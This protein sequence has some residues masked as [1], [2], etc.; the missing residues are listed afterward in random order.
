MNAENTR[1]E[2]L[3]T[4]SDGEYIAC[5]CD[6]A[7]PGARGEQD[8][9]GGQWAEFLWCG[10]FSSDMTGAKALAVAQWGRENQRRV[11]RF[12]Y[13]GHGQSSG[14]F[15]DGTIGRWKDDAAF[16]RERLS[17]GRQILIGSSMGGWIS[18]LLALEKPQNLAGLLL[19]AP[20]PD[21][22]ERLLWANFSEQERE[23][24][25]KQGFLPLSDPDAGEEY[26]EEYVVTWRQ[27]QE[28][29]QHLLPAG[30]L[31][32]SCPVRIIHGMSDAVVPWRHSLELVERIEA[33]DIAITLVKDSDHRLSTPEDLARIQDTL[34][35]MTRLAE[36]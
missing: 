12:D 27:I 23:L 3:L 14:A 4:R 34:D 5:C 2:E 6:G 20:A 13:F 36:N 21:F 16:V 9:Q 24:C 8:G 18:L 30:K 29:R 35:E 1:R 22:T 7:P 25:Q 19:L 10:G 15:K 26:D 28:A 31:K 32:I 17:G 11:V 33:R